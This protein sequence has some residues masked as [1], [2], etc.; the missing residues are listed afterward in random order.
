MFALKCGNLVAVFGDDIVPEVKKPITGRCCRLS[1][2]CDA[3]MAFVGKQWFVYRKIDD[4]VAN[5]PEGKVAV[6]TF[7][8]ITMDDALALEDN[9]A[10]IP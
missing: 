8:V 1:S 4:Y 2:S 10:L 9:L 3:T 5:L 6:P 7:E